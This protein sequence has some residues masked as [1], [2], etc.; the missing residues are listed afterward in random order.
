MTA[1][2]ADPPVAASGSPAADALGLDLRI[3]TPENVVLTYQ[4]AGPA[5]R[6]GAYLLDLC[7]RLLVWG[8]GIIVVVLTMGSLPGLGMGAFFLI[9]FLVEWAYYVV[10]EWGFN[11]KTVG[12]SALGLRVVHERGHPITLWSSM[13]RNLL[14][15]ADGLPYLPL[16]AT[17]IPIYGVGLIAIVL[18]RRLQRL[19]DLAAGTVV[20]SERHVVLPREPIII[21]RI[22]PLP[23]SDLGRT[24]PGERTLSLIEEFLSRRSVLSHERGHAVCAGL[25]RALAARLG[26]HGDAQLVERYPM[27]FLARVYVTFLRRDE[28]EPDDEAVWLSDVRPAGPRSTREPRPPRGRRQTSGPPELRAELIEEPLRPPRRR[29]PGEV[30]RRRIEREPDS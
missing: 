1:D 3:E 20:I 11:G 9:W 22:D 23:R 10:L 30:L 17:Q 27:A 16:A 28:D 24:A 14:R 25:A 18:S 26:Y 4:L 13:L 8:A 6:L 21:E 15:A 2:V 7:I 29:P 5:A 19:G 12:K